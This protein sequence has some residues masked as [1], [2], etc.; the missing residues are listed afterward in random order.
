MDETSLNRGAE[1]KTWV[2]PLNALAGMT[3][4]VVA[5]CQACG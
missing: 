4:V 3:L 5:E 1:W 2:D